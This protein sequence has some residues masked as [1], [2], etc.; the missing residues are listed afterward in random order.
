MSVCRSRHGKQDETKLSS[1]VAQSLS[2]PQKPQNDDSSLVHS[3]VRALAP[4][5][6]SVREASRALNNVAS[7]Q[8]RQPSPRLAAVTT[9]RAF[10]G[11]SHALQLA[12]MLHTAQHLA[13]FNLANRLI[14][15]AR[16]RAVLLWDRRFCTLSVLAT[17]R[18][19]LPLGSSRSGM[20]GYRNSRRLCGDVLCP[21][22]SPTSRLFHPVGRQTD[23]TAGPVNSLRP[24]SK[25]SMRSCFR[26]F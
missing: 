21:V 25:N 18:L 23:T 22:Y 5:G 19:G 13:G 1:V 11:P 12:P 16:R 17:H 14:H 15:A 4:S 26:M 6:R 7:V 10:A 8:P 3:L 24:G 9:A 20:L 2:T